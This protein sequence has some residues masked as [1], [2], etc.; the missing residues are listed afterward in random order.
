MV[1]YRHPRPQNPDDPA[2]VAITTTRVRRIEHIGPDDLAKLARGSEHLR[3]LLDR[4]VR[5]WMGVPIVADG[6]T[7]GLLELFDDASG[8]SFGEE[9][10]AT[11][12]SFAARV[13]I[14]AAEARRGDTMT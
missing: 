11:A 13:A 12:R 10:V 2:W 1:D 4:E 5:S 9:S 6:R 7:F 14:A 8:R 3:M